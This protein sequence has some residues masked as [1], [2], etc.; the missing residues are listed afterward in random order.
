MENG[1]KAG[2]IKPVS[3]ISEDFMFLRNIEDVDGYLWGIIYLDQVIFQS[4]KNLIP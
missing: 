2:G 1:I 4:Y 3:S